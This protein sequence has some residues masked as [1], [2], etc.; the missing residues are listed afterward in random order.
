MCKM[1]YLICIIYFKFLVNVMYI[2]LS[3]FEVYG[4]DLF[5]L[6]NWRKY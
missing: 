4:L 5:N 6:F 3:D 1:Y 2:L